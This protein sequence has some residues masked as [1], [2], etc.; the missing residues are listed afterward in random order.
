MYRGIGIAGAILIEVQ[1]TGS[2]V[3]KELRG[4][5]RSGWRRRA[6]NQRD[7]NACGQ[8]EITANDLDDISTRSEIR[9]AVR[10][11][12]GADKSKDII[13]CAAGQRVVAGA[14]GQRIFMP[15]CWLR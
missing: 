12:I 10:A 4:S 2:D 3:V 15:R 11:L 14:A 9:N 7:T 5:T 13:A 6:G 8:T 1:R